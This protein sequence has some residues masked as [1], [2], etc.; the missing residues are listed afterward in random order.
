MRKNKQNTKT[1]EKQYYQGFY[2]PKNPKKYQ[3]D[4]SK[5]VYRSSW[6]R[7]FMTYCDTQ[8]SVVQWSSEEIIIT[9]VSPKDGNYHRYFVDFK[10]TVIDSKG[11][12]STLLIE[13]KPLREVFPPAKQGKSRKSYIYQVQT[14]LVNKAKWKAAEELCRKKGWKFIIATDKNMPKSMINESVDHKIWKIF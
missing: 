13:V 5:I 8:D 2:R 12:P 10:M 14:Y 4:I 1:K 3:G 7:K 9:Y 6:E 11:L